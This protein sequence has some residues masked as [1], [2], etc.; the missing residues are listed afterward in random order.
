[1]GGQLPLAE[2]RRGD[3]G[4]GA[5]QADD[6]DRHQG[7]AEVGS[8]PV[9]QRSTPGTVPAAVR[10]GPSRSDEG[11]PWLAGS[12]LGGGPRRSQSAVAADRG[13]V[14]HVEHGTNLPAAGCRD[15]GSDGLPGAG[16]RVSPVCPSNV[17]GLCR[18][19]GPG[20]VRS[21]GTAR[22]GREDLHP[23]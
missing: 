23:T 12:L 7:P 10:R 19:F 4:A 17:T 5:E 9:G 18:G 16:A 2:A 14:V 22:L 15:G 6:E 8:L 11:T 13:D 21:I 1:M 20:P 3:R